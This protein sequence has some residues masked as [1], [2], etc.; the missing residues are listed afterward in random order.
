MNKDEEI[1]SLCYSLCNTFCENYKEELNE[2]SL[3]LEIVYKDDS[4][5]IT[6]TNIKDLHK[7]LFNLI[8]NNNDNIKEFNLINKQ[9][10]K[11]LLLTLK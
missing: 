10:K 9:N 3:N 6:I 1:Y 2:E 8:K 7:V 11:I 5:Y 4:N